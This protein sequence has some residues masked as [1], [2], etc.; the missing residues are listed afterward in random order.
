MTFFCEGLKY[1]IAPGKKVHADLGYKSSRPDETMLAVPNPRD[2]K[3]L[4][5]FKSRCRLR[6]ETFNGRIKCF[7]V[8]SETFRHG[9]EKHKLAM[10]AVCVIVQ[11]QMENGQPIF[12]P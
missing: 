6:H 8:L 7:N 4:Y 3:P 1:K 12:D 5:N 9:E 11:Y 2:S 10:E